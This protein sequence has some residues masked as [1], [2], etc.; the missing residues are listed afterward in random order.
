M[1]SYKTTL[2]GDCSLWLITSKTAIWDGTPYSDAQRNV[3]SS[4]EDSAPTTP[5]WFN[6]GSV[7]GEDPWI[8]TTDHFDALANG[9]FVYGEDNYG[10]PHAAPVVPVKGGVFVFIRDGGDLDTN[11]CS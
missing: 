10:G 7:P 9:K 11:G 2:S 6:R 8:S 4:S 1:I 5:R 3:C